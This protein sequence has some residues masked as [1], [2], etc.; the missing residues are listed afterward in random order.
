VI[1][2][3]R[4]MIGSEYLKWVKTRTPGRFS[5]AAGGVLPCS[6]AELGVGIDDLEINSPGLHGY[7]PLQQAIA[8]HCLWT[9]CANAPASNSR[10]P[11]MAH[12]S[13][14]EYR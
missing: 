10:R 14:H 8:A 5:L 13:S 11:I 4:L 6:Q 7:A 12:A 3:T 2:F 9:S 1:R